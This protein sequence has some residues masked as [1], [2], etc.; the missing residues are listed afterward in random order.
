M[1]KIKEQQTNRAK[2][3]IL[4]VDDVPQNVQMLHQIL[5]S[6]DYSFAIATG[7][8][9]TLQLVKKQLP[10]L[11]LLDIMLGD[12]DGFDVCR[13]IKA[14]PVSAAVPII[15][16]TA[17]VELEDKVKGFKLGAVDYITKPFEDAEV[18]A[19]VHTHIQ[20]KKSMDMINDYN[21]QLLQAYEEMQKSYRE[22]KDTQD[23]RIEREKETALKAVSVTATHEMNQPLTVIQGYLDLFIESLE[24]KALNPTQKK[25]LHRIEDGLQK[26][27]EIIDNFRRHT[28]LYFM[29]GDPTKTVSLAE[30]LEK[31]K[32][33][34][35]NYK[36]Q[37][38]F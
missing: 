32:A 8:K 10:D 3:L 12:I 27:V 28:H 29:G 34:L 35:R 2:P 17:K 21:R 11:I 15:F 25:Y 22:M 13:Q 6:G 9:E 36:E 18:V 38:Q 20:L 33:Q 1:K 16:L 31:V 37:E 24:M 5:N 19:R 26:L 7:G 4:L 14:D 30:K 23:E